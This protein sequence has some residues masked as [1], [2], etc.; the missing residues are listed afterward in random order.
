MRSRSTKSAAR[1]AANSVANRAP[2]TGLEV[3]IA[4]E[5]NEICD[6]LL[7]R[8]Q[9]TLSTLHPQFHGLTLPRMW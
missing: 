2:P 5:T 3:R 1:A 8:V 9:A 6:V 7:Q 4:V